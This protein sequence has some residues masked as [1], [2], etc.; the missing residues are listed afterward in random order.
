MI[1][2]E[3]GVIRNGLN[4]CPEARCV[5]FQLFGIRVYAR[6]VAWRRLPIFQVYRIKGD[7]R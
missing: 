1:R 3:G 4:I 6:L 5:T 2:R 7:R